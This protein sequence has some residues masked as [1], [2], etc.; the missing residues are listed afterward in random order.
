MDSE[1]FDI[2]HYTGHKALEEMLR[3][4]RL[5]TTP[6]DRALYEN[7]IQFSSYDFKPKSDIGDLSSSRT[8]QDLEIDKIDHINAFHFGGYLR[9]L[10]KKE[11][12]YCINSSVFFQVMMETVIND[13]LGNDNGSFFSKWDKFLKDNNASDDELD[14]FKQ[15]FDNIYK[16]IRIPTVHPK[17]RIGLR[18]S[19]MFRFNHI[20]EYIKRG[21]FSFV[22]LLNKQNGWNMNKE[23]NWEQMCRMNNVPHDISSE[24]FI[25]IEEFSGLLYKK[26]LDTLNKNKG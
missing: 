18:N 9:S 6:I 25:D 8:I 15:Y 12:E 22:F 17:E 21:W 3:C 14:D 5:Y 10:N 7:N 23:E 24:Q 20:H 11:I 2:A 16:G 1:H 19:Q 26:H 13:A 4:Y